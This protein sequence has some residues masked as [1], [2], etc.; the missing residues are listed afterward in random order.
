MRYTP[1]RL[2]TDHPEL[3]TAENAE[4]I[5]T[6]LNASSGLHRPE[7]ADRTRDLA[8]RFNVPNSER[9]NIYITR[10]WLWELHAAC[11]RRKSNYPTTPE[12]FSRDLLTELISRVTG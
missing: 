10:Q 2:I 8:N 12:H 3:A 4:A 1:A 9:K 7:Q 6:E 11:S 5:R